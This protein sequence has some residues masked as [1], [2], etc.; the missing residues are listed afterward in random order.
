M[1]FCKRVYD[2]RE[3]QDGCRVLVDRLWPRGL[4]RE[5]A[6][7]DEWVKDAAP[8]GSLR[9]WYG[10]RPERWPEFQSRYLLELEKEGA[11]QALE[12]LR[13]YAAAGNV[14]L[15]TATR[16]VEQ[17]HAAVLASVLKKARGRAGS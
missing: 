7:I 6:A 1:I 2:Q 4:T 8:S 3:A 9:A 13:T 11:A 16:H 5:K 12:R 17:S 14:T 10:H 15:L